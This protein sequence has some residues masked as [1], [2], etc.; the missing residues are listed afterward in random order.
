MIASSVKLKTNAIFLFNRTVV[1]DSK[2]CLGRKK[3]K[4]NVDVDVVSP[5][6]LL[7]SENNRYLNIHIFFK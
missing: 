3:V 4:E 5:V 6:L 1:Y 2:T 7:V